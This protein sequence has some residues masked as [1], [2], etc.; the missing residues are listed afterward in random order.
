MKQSQFALKLLVSAFFMLSGFASLWGQNT[1]M[2]TVTGTVIDASS[3][4]PVIGAYISL[5]SSNKYGAMTDFDGGFVLSIP[6]ATSG[7]STF[8]IEC[9]GFEDKTLTLSEIQA[10]TKI[11]L[12]I[13]SELLDEV[14]VVGYGTQ[15]K[16]SSVGSISQTSGAEIQRAGNMNSVSEALQGKLNGVVAFNS[17]GQ[18]GANSATIYIRGKSSWQSS[19]PLVLVDGIERNMDDV[20]FNEIESLS[21]LK[22]ASA[23]AVYG[24]R[25]A[26][27]VILLTTKRGT[28]DH[29]TV[30]FSANM[31]LKSPTA[32][33]EWA[34][35]I[36]S[37]KMYNEANANE[38]NWGNMIPESTIA[39]WENAFATG[40]YGPYN[41]VFPNVDWYDEILQTAVSHNYN[42]NINGK[43]EFMKYFASVGYQHDGSIYN[44]P[45]AEDYDP[46]AYFNRL[47]WRA[48]FD[49]NLTK[50]TV[51]SVNVAGKMSYRNSQFYSDVYSKL[52]LAPNNSFPIKYSNGYWGDATNQGA[53]PIADITAG[54][55]V[56]H[57]NYQ[58]WYDVKLNQDL[59]FI[60]KGLKAHAQVSY[61][62]YSTNRDRIRTGGIFGGAEFSQMNAFPREYRTYDYSNPIEMED[63]TI[64]YPVIENKSGFHG[65][66][67]YTTPPGV[68]FDATTNLASRLYYEVGVN[69]NRTFAGHE[70][71]AM[72]LWNRQ[73]A[74]SSGGSSFDFPSFRED[75]VGRVT[76]NW[77]ERYLFEGNVSYTGSEKFAPGKR[78]GLFPSFSAGWRL[79]EEPWMK[80]SKNVLSNFKVRYSWGKVG[81]DAGASRFQYI[82]LFNQGGT[83][84]FGKDEN[85]AFGPTYSEGAVA[86]PNATW[87]SAIKQ[88]LGIEFSLF[89]KLSVA[90]DLYDEQ[91]SGILLSPRTTAA[92]VGVSIAAANLGRTK[93]HGIDLEVKWNDKIGSAFHYF[94]NFAFS[95]SENRVVFRDDPQNFLDYQRDAGK[96]INWQTRYLVTGNYETI[97]DIFNAAKPGF[98]AATTII[99]GDFTYIDFDADGDVDN[100]DKVVVD[101]LNY[102]LTTY[103]LT[104]GFDWKGLSFSAMMYSPQG[105][106]KNYIN[107]YLW[108]FPE[109]YVKAQPQ[110]SE[111]WTYATANR[112]GIVR[113]TT[114][115]ANTANNKTESTYR[116]SDYSY[117]RLKNVEI[118]YTI[119]K[120]WQKAMSMTNCRVFVSGNNL[121]TWW[122][123]DY[124][125]DPETSNS[126]GTVNENANIYPILRT[127]TVGLRFAF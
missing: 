34:D 123:G 21:V 116:F 101:R 36:T 33:G 30:T 12:N 112:E 3:G 2:K 43:S 24:V 84:N 6:S 114:H 7:R 96:P 120:R 119:P 82:Q 46:R 23:T 35:H 126:D 86:Q 93:N 27:G 9:V 94:V 124:R 37:M 87:E 78:Y 58:G 121:L 107:A 4:E 109:G 100:Q 56:K 18:P 42:V 73:K 106:H 81:T 13:K 64:M 79:T 103:S 8:T 57:K 102:P 67:Y 117:I 22:D 104:V 49:F 115:L 127:Y 89:K 52:T 55:Q 39:A 85:T 66:K 97:D 122:K 80:W 113:P 74:E 54:G 19:S 59:S 1:N 60:T 125:I 91:R 53:N 51:F 63:G 31:G 70:V 88:N 16:A 48:N 90:V 45:K 25:G 14:V 72:A 32:T 118:S 47:N 5:D 95:T 98:A 71:G 68:D 108:D 28:S 15:K 75:W 110:S 83:V 11:P 20:D 44:I 41:D 38:G 26:N 69:Y 50:T 62:S 40:N 61:N 99:P 76:Y 77:K 17:T 105:V 29:P 10:S 92:W 111:R 65:N